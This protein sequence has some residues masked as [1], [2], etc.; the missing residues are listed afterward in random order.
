MRGCAS[1]TR[2]AP[3]TSRKTYSTNRRQCLKPPVART[4]PARVTAR[5]LHSEEA[6]PAC[7][8]ARKIGKILD[9]G[10]VEKVGGGKVR[11]WFAQNQL[12]DFQAAGRSL[13][14]TTKHPTHSRHTE[15]YAGVFQQPDRP[16]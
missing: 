12:R 5:T 2:P 9:G 7:T 15:R 3:T 11:G 16:Q 4:W 1:R 8:G 13:V 14:R 10:A 6:C